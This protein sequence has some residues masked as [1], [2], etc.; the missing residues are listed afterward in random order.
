LKLLKSCLMATLVFTAVAN[1]T[2][3]PAPDFSKWANKTLQDKGVTGAR[4]VDTKYPFYFTFCQKNS[5]TLWRYDVMSIEQL[6]AI[7]QGKTVKPVTEAEKT[8]QVE[9]DSGSCKAAS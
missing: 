5:L 2:G 9:T 3:L 1:A 4:V 6:D 7:Q 8:V